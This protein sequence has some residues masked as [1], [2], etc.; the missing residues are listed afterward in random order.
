MAAVHRRDRPLVQGT[1]V[2]S[3]P[4]QALSW[5]Q[6]AQLDAFREKFTTLVQ[7]QL[8]LAS[9]SP[10]GVESEVRGNAC[11]RSEYVEHDGWLV[12]IGSVGH[13]TASRASGSPLSLSL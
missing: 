1:R 9:V 4:L 5:V 2:A 13:A 3:P 7:V 8:A 11:Q 6:A 10:E 12:D